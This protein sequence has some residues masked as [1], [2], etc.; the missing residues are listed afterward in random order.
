MFLSNILNA[1]IS[2]KFHLSAITFLIA[3]FVSASYAN[4]GQIAYAY[5]IENIK[6]DGDLSDWSDNLTR[7]PIINY[8]SER[9]TENDT[10]YKAFFRVGY[11]E[12]N[13]SLY[14]AVE[15]N[16]DSYVVAKD[17]NTPWEAQDRFILYLDKNHF[18][19]GSGNVYYDVAEN[20]REINFAKNNW[21]PMNAKATWKNAN[22]KLSRKGNK[23]IC[24]WKV[25]LGNDVHANKSIG[26]DYFMVDRD[27][28]E[29]DSVFLTWGSGTSKSV[30]TTNLG[31]LMLIEKGK[32]LAELQGKVKW[33]SNSKQPLPNKIRISSVNNPKLWV[34]ANVDKEGNY[35]AKMPI[36]EYLIDSPFETSLPFVVDAKAKPLR[37]DERIKERIVIKENQ[38]NK[39]PD[40]ELV[41][42][43]PPEYLIQDKGVLYD[44]DSSKSLK[45][46]NFIETYRRYYGVPGVSV[47][48]VKD[49]KVVYHK[50][51]GV[52]K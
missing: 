11:N 29:K 46:D 17:K 14:F 9:K 22:Y 49:G 15:I 24:E 48:L 2:T 23:T 50:T 30:V 43:K 35:S 13:K 44:Y 37:I 34:M 52:K 26:M 41:T 27:K 20:N 18:R 36:G 25:F 8:M 51:F 4:N 3:A 1:I 7:F 32:P 16:D 40:L 47:A 10:D 19:R 21:D 33:K 42:F 39:A 45:I 31:D 6:I 28:N 38:I 5:P 12:K